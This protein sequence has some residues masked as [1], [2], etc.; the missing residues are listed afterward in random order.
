MRPRRKSE[1]LEGCMAVYQFLLSDN[2]H[3]VHSYLHHAP[4]PSGLTCI[5][6]KIVLVTRAKVCPVSILVRSFMPSFQRTS[7]IVVGKTL[8]YLKLTK[9][10]FQHFLHQINPPRVPPV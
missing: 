6:S 9:N 3:H 4:I 1:L 5:D 2:R 8:T 10:G 7:I